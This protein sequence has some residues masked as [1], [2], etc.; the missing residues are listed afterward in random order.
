[1][2]V[3]SV[4]YTHLDVYKRQVRTLSTLRERYT[5]VVKRVVRTLSTFRERYTI[6]VTIFYEFRLVSRVDEFFSLSVQQ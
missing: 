1:M 6:V 5:I 2:C 4:S 3:R